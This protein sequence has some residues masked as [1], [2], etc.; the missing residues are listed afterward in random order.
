MIFKGRGDIQGI[1]Y[2][3]DGQ[4]PL[5]AKVSLSAL[6]VQRAGPVGMKFVYTEHSRI[7]D[8]DFSS[9]EFAFQN[10]FVGPIVVARCFNRTG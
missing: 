9:G 2:D 8:N 4:T 6:R 5:S 3:D 10:V 1:V 7:V